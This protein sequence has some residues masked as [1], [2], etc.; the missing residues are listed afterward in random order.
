MDSVILRSHNL[1]EVTSTDPVPS[2]GELPSALT[3]PF[4]NWTPKQ[5]YDFL[6]TNAPDT[7]FNSDMFVLIDARS[8]E[9]Y[10]CLLCTKV[11]EF[12]DDDDDDDDD[13]ENPM[14]VPRVT[15]ESF[16]TLRATFRNS[17]IS[18]VNW[19]IANMDIDEDTENAESTGGVSMIGETEESRARDMGDAM[20]KEKVLRS[21][22]V[23]RE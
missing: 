19:D 15:G 10:T 11:H 22:K 1:A 18:L 23:V 7:K 17:I 3:S 2:S 9:D 13:E 14:G 4:P 8:Q 20:F 21:G 12:D 5:C 16:K 6:T